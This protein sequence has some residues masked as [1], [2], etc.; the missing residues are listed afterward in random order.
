MA[1][2]DRGRIAAVLAADAHFQAWAGGTAVLHSHLDQ[3]THTHRV[4]LLERITGQD[5]LLHVAQQEFAF[6]SSRL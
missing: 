3:L 1:E 4:Q 5:L 2:L 6:A